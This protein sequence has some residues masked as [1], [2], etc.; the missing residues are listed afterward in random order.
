VQ[1]EVERA[2]DPRDPDQREHDHELGDAATRHV[3]GEVVG[4]LRHDG[5]VHQVEEQ[6]EEADDAPGDRLTVC[7]RGAPQPASEAAC[8]RL[9]RHRVKVPMATQ[10]LMQ[11]IDEA[12][13]AR[14]LAATQL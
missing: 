11:S 10:R 6:F 7:S 13:D 5:H 9:I 12:V 1:L 3:I 2:V 8:E 4:R 14:G